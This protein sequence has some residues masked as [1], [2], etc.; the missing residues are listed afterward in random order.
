LEICQRY[1]HITMGCR[2]TGRLETAHKRTFYSM[3]QRTI[4]RGVLLACPGGPCRR[5]YNNI[6]L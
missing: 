1:P 4:L 5:A 6:K 3:Y 2:T